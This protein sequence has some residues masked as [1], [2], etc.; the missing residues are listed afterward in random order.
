MGDDIWALKEE[1]YSEYI[2]KQLRK[3]IDNPK[4]YNITG[5]L[6]IF[7]RLYKKEWLINVLI[8]II[9]KNFMCLSPLFLKNLLFW[10][11]NKDNNKSNYEGFIWAFLIFMV[12]SLRG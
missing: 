7:W 5:L 10:Y 8:V 11:E 6:S 2:I 9:M 3:Y 12:Q 4:K 1:F